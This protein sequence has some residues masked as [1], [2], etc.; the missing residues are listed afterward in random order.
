MAEDVINIAIVAF[1][2]VAALVLFRLCRTRLSEADRVATQACTAATGKDGHDVGPDALLLL[3]DLDAH[4]AKLAG[5]FEELGPPPTT[6]EGLAQL[7]Q[8][9]RDEQQKGD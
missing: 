3:Q 6:A 7:R 5:L 8:A 2:A 9:V 1:L 4:F